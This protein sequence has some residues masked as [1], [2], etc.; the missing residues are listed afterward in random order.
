MDKC[1]S[2]SVGSSGSASWTAD[3]DYVLDSV[4]W[5]G[6]GAGTFAALSQDPAFDPNVLASGIRTSAEF[7]LGF[8][9]LGQ[10]QVQLGYPIAKG[11]IVVL[12]CLAGGCNVLLILSAAVI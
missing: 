12:N 9:G 7:A 3:S 8:T 5:D 1:I 6:Q 4:V 10:L 2:L 11:S